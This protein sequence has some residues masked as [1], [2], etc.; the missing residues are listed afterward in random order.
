ME[1]TCVRFLLENLSRLRLHQADLISDVKDQMER[2]ENNLLLFK[3]FLNE[4][5][6]EREEEDEI[7][8]EVTAQM[9]EVVY[10]AEDGVDVYVSQALERETE[11]YFRRAS[12]PPG[13]LLGVV[14][15]EVES[16]GTRVKELYD[17]LDQRQRQR[18]RQRQIDIS[19]SETESELLIGDASDSTPTQLQNLE[20]NQGTS[21]RE[22][23]VVGIEDETDNII[24][25]LTKETEEFDVI[26]IVGMAGLGK[27][28][29]ARKIFRDPR[30]ANEF[31]IRLW[32][33]V[34][35]VY[36]VKRYISSY[37]A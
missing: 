31:P 32:V 17:D 21:V 26:S 14:V 36:R 10:K 35:Q 4:S 29:L 13:K 15:E 2:L 6:Q 20:R 16:T 3:R 12:D 25:Y 19:R 28:T 9:R 8:E 1:D 23:I 11:K 22:D 5:T 27:T 24:R 30:I 37:V 33:S 7:L 18:Q 34:S